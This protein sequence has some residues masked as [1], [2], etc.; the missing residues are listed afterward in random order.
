MLRGALMLGLLAPV[1]VGCG[2]GVAAP[3]PPPSAAAQRANGPAAARPARRYGRV[4]HDA[5]PVLM[6]HVIARPPE[7]TPYPG[8]WT[9]PRAFAGQ[10]A[11]LQRAGFHGVTLDDAVEHWRRGLDLPAHPVVVSFDDGYAGQRRAAAPVLRRLRWP[12]VLDLEVHNL[13]VAGGLR[14]SDVRALLRDCWELASHTL[15]H[16]DLTTL[17]P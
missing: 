12:G 6:Y 8:L 14:P 5:I 1:L 7:G 3:A 17:A 13:H 15:T 4:G 9:A 2:S 16:P 11:A 10:M